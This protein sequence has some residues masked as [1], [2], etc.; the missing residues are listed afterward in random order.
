MASKKSTSR[1]GQATVE[2]LLLIV[3]LVPIIIYVTS[4]TGTKVFKPIQKWLKSEIGSQ[5]RYG[6]SPTAD[7]GGGNKIKDVLVPDNIDAI[8]GDAPL[9]YGPVGS[10][11]PVHPMHSV[12]KGWQ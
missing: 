1:T 3:I 7:R 11:K 2:M 4:A 12:K 10:I 8:S 9:M 5:V 6:Y